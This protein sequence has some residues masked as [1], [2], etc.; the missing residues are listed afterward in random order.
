MGS[1]ISQV[2]GSSPQGGVRARTVVLASADVD[3]RGRLRRSLSALRWT[4]LEAGGGA[5]A[6]ELT[7]TGKPEALLIDEWLPDL[8]AGELMTQLRM[9]YPLMD[10]LRMDGAPTG[11]A[12]TGRSPRRHEL[13]HAIRE[14]H[15]AS[16][17]PVSLPVQAPSSPEPLAAVSV[18][19]EMVYPELTE[20]EVKTLPLPAA[21]PMAA[22]APA[23]A[24]VRAAGIADMVG[25]SAAM[26]ELARMIRLVAPRSATVLIEGET[27]TGKEVVAKAVHRLSARAGKPFGVLN[28]AAIPES[29]LEAELFGHTR[30]AF[31]GAVQSR[32][33]RIEAAN[34]GTLFLDEIGE[35]PL[36]L[37]AKMLRFL[38]Y[39]ELQRVGDN[40]TMRVDV[41]VIAATHQPLEQRAEEKAFRLDLYYWLRLWLESATLGG[42]GR[43]PATT[44]DMEDHLYVIGQ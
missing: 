5:E 10:V 6:M 43:L 3:L 1:L 39:G 25:E 4:V 11:G 32:T 17:A 30:G 34:G 20:A 31:T 26:R 15:E 37:Q 16:P 27:G 2:A 38:E 14:A 12:A 40:E 18:A 36:A 9:I 44:A 42:P 22:E 24:S 21:A 8:E 33:G 35:M 29:L 28:C 23:A 41:R 13:L 19:S 7:D